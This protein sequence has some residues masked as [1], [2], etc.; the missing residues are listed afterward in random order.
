M[1]LRSEPKSPSLEARGLLA[2]LVLGLVALPNPG[3]SQTIE[4]VFDPYAAG[5]ATTIYPGETGLGATDLADLI[6]WYVPGAGVARMWNGDIV[7]S[8]RGGHTPLTGTGQTGSGAP[9]G[10]GVPGTPPSPGIPT[11]S[12]G[13]GGGL[14]APGNPLLIVD[15]YKVSNE[16]FSW[17]LRSLSPFRVERMVVLRDLA[18]TAM[19]GI[20]GARGIILVYTRRR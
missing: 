6:Q 1:S 12:S 9:P 18:S 8:L 2:A 14:S 15:G 20:R 10:S 4:R 17:R 11:G 16:D 7:V 3:S 19:Y 5:A 13:Q